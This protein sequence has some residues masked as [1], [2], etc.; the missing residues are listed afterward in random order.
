MHCGNA[1]PCTVLELDCKLI[2]EH[3]G[4]SPVKLR[5]ILLRYKVIAGTESVNAVHDYLFDEVKGVCRRL[6]ICRR[7]YGN[8]DLVYRGTGREKRTVTGLP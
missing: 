8:I 5:E 7:V 2:I 1:L 3:T 4:H 6:L